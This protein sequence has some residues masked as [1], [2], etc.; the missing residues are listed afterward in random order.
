MDT[1]PAMECVMSLEGQLAFS[2]HP[3]LSIVL[4]EPECKII[5]N[6]VNIFYLN[7]FQ[8]LFLRHRV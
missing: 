3:L 7:C 4:V 8:C 6:H 5:L 2:F 1:F